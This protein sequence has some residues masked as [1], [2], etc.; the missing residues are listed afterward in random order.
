MKRILVWDIPTRLFHWLLAAS[1]AVAWASSG[2]DEWLSV[3]G[4]SGYLMLG[5][6]VFRLIWGVAGG[7]YAR[8]SSFRHGSLAGLAYL[9]QLLAGHAR[10]HI[11]HNPAGAQAVFLMLAL[12]L[13]VCLTGVLTQGGEEGH[14]AAAG[15]TGVAVGR[16]FKE[17]H[18]IAATLMLLVVIGHLAGVA[19]E[20]WRHRENLPRAMITGFKEAPDEALDDSPA[21]RRYPLVGASLLLS[22]I[23]FGLWWFSYALPA[24]L[25]PKSTADGA[26]PQVAFV[27][28]RLPDDPQ[29]REECGSCHLA[30]HPNLLPARSWRKLVAEQD[31]HF[32]ADLALDAPTAQ[33]L[34]VFME[35]NAAERGPTEAAFKIE[36][37][38]RDGATPL[39]ITETPYWIKKHK[40]IA[41]ADWRL[42]QVDSRANCAACH[43]D[44]EAG[45]FEDAAMHIPKAAP[46]ARF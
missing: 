24:A 22:A 46:N 4:F 36:R 11:G 28:A 38:L 44:A 41:P 17:A 10:R 19:L 43:R 13:A 37:S 1:F 23:A 14:G 6:I 32:G 7:N 27:G 3:H 9:R 12:G 33:A 8:F 15:L 29:W 31:K 20:S 40:E 30:F 42:P 45:T 16:L 25:A 26:A 35:N 21:S 5:L 39:R 2:S 34:L 18:E